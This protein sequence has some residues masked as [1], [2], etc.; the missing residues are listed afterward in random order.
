MAGLVL[1]VMEMQCGKNVADVI[2]ILRCQI[3]AEALLF[4][5]HDD[6]TTVEYG[7]GLGGRTNENICESTIV[8]Y[9]V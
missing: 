9:F 8:L 7:I 2:C 4:I 1:I 5:P 3:A 6:V